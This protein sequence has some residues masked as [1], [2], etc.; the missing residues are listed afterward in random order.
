MLGLSSVLRS[1]RASAVEAVRSGHTRAAVIGM[2]GNEAQARKGGGLAE[3]G[4]VETTRIRL[5]VRPRTSVVGGS[6]LF[7]TCR[8]CRWLRRMLTNTAVDWKSAVPSIPYLILRRSTVRWPSLKTPNCTSKYAP[9][10]S[11]TIDTLA[12]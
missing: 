9:C 1:S 4:N 7:V 5:Y 6:G 12:P 2:R 11:V 3:I 10:L 8:R